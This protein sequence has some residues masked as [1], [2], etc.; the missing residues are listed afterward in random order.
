MFFSC[1]MLF[2]LAS[3]SWGCDSNPSNN[4]DTALDSVDGFIDPDGATCSHN[5]PQCIT[6]ADC[7]TGSQCGSG[8]PCLPSS[9]CDYTNGST[10]CSGDCVPVCVP[11]DRPDSD[12]DGVPDLSDN[13]PY[14]YNPGQ[15]DGDG[16]GVGDACEG[17]ICESSRGCASDADCPMGAA[18]GMGSTCQPSTCCRNEITGESWCT[19]DC[20]LTCNPVEEQDWDGDGVPDLRDNCPYVYNP[21]QLDQNGNGVGDACE[22]MNDADGDGIFDEKDNCP[23]LFNPDQMDSNNNGVGD[24][25]EGTV[26]CEQNYGD[27]FS[28]F[29]C[30]PYEICSYGGSVCLPSQCCYDEFTGER[31]C[32]ADCL[33]QCIPVEGYDSDGDGIE[34]QRDN[35]RDM[36]NPDQADSDGDGVGDVCDTSLC[37]DYVPCT[38]NAMCGAGEVCNLVDCRPSQCCTDASGA[39]VCTRDCLATCS[40]GAD[41]DSDGIED[42][43]DNCLNVANPGQED[44]DVDGVGDACDASSCVFN[45]RCLD[46]SYCNADQLCDQA[47]CAPSTCCL[48]AGSLVCTADCNAVCLLG[49][50]SDGDRITN[51]KDNC[52]NVANPTQ[53]DSNGDGV[54][55]ACSAP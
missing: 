24:A 13:C 30:G 20:V 10:L 1:L 27:C 32:T 55:D 19:A 29:D 50:D 6:D 39:Q 51:T 16:N 34:D 12:Q 17:E 52:P 44:F 36:P 42:G 8:P 37:V 33:P 31:W 53:T 40:L 38:S 28:D 9:C 21:D 46:D 54:G 26:V 22:G 23:Y 47:A 5:S 41:A 4:S 11:V 49:P 7:P 15:E 25:C 45:R 43:K 48:T 35:C 3:V 2:L 14:S 18:C